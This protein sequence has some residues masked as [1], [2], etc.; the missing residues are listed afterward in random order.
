MK[1]L[2]TADL[3]LGKTLNGYSLLSDQEYIIKKIEDIILSEN[4]DVVVVAGDIFDRA[5]AS[6]EALDL[7]GDFLG[8]VNKNNK[9]LIAILGNHDGDRVAY[10][11]HLLKYN[12]INIIDEPQKIKI[13]DVIFSCI[14]YRNIHQLKD[15]YNEDF[16]TLDEAYSYILDDFGFDS[17][18]F[19]MLIAHDY[20]T[21][22]MEKLEESESEIN[23]NVG[24]LDYLDIEMFNKYDYVALGHM[25]KAQRVGNDMHRYS[26]SILKYSFSEVN[27]NK[28]V[29]IVDSET[30]SYYLI[31]LTPKRDLVDIKGTI[32]ELANETFY[33]NY[34]YK[35]DFFR[36]ILPTNEVNAYSE[37]KAIYPFL[38][39]IK[40]EET[41]EPKRVLE[42]KIAQEKDYLELFKMFYYEMENKEMTL[43]EKEIVKK[44]LIGGEE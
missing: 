41:R 39:E 11:N 23:F 8:F 42:K 36:A 4:V 19:N 35:N 2:H 26:G 33:K 29:V 30:K 31:P 16:K 37:L 10:L 17:S 3:H 5:I 28:S 9:H 44:Y 25:H 34:N 14:P 38:M 27:S 1:I 24:G 7:F 32:S 12:N 18:C 15:Y 20:F 6:K 13:N 43:E 22:H 21:Y 40:V